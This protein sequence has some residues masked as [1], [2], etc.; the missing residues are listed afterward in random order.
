MFEG[1]LINTWMKHQDNLWGKIFYKA[2]LESYYLK[3]S[4]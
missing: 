2:N 4:N 3:L 1:K